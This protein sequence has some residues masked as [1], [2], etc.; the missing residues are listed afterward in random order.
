[1]RQRVELPSAAL[2]VFLLLVYIF[3]TCISHLMCK[4]CGAYVPLR[5]Y[6]ERLLCT[7]SAAPSY[8]NIA[9]R[10]AFTASICDSLHLLTAA[11]YCR[12]VAPIDASTVLSERSVV[13]H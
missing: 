2:L 9:A 7:L 6:A 13:Q 11:P 3:K 4:P 8:A 1:M 12:P 10:L 5:W